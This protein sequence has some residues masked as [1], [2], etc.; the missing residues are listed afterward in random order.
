MF[1]CFSKCS[2]GSVVLALKLGG[3]WF[4]HYSRNFD[5]SMAN[6]GSRHWITL[7]QSVLYRHC[8][9][10]VSILKPSVYVNPSMAD[11][12]WSACGC[13]AA[14]EIMLCWPNGSSVFREVENWLF[15][16]VIKFQTVA[17][18]LRALIFFYCLFP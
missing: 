6:L 17:C 16:W 3:I 2:N 10:P 18:H 1:S 5:K 9:I 14:V 7:P 15:L 4:I 8:E 11:A 12:I 13:R